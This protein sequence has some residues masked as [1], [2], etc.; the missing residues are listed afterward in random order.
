MRKA[1]LLDTSFFIR[2]LN[3]EDPLF[4][5]AEGYYRY[6]IQE[7]FDLV[8]STISIAEY[9]VKGNVNELPLLNLQV[10]PFNLNHGTMAGHLASIA[11]CA[12]KEKAIELKQRFIIPNDT[13]L[14]AQAA[15][16]EYIS[17]YLSSDSESKKIYDLIRINAPVRFEFIDLNIPYTQ[18]FGTI[19][20]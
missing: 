14:F 6:L 13:K 9:C 7:K 2:F 18:F 19:G 8:I 20:L 12:R 1:V 4:I 17:F 3:E 16:E 5:N 11:F 10:L 15:T